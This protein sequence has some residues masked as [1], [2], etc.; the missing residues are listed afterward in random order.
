[1]PS[2]RRT[3]LH[4]SHSPIPHHLPARHH[5][6]IEI[7]LHPRLHVHCLI[8]ENTTAFPTDLLK[9]RRAAQHTRPRQ[10]EVHQHRRSIAIQA[11][12]R[13]RPPPCRLERCP[14]DL[15]VLDAV[16]GKARVC[17]GSGLP[18]VQV[19]QEAVVP[20]PHEQ[21]ERKFGGDSGAPSV[22]PTELTCRI[23]VGKA[24]RRD[25]NRLPYCGSRGSCTTIACVFHVKIQGRAASIKESS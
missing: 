18:V 24:L 9:P 20:F 7:R 21:V 19:V 23:E 22:P 17:N 10:P 1:M 25:V 6:P 3:C 12:P 15:T 16:P 5:V 11:N 14:G 2:L 8:L 4:L 13:N